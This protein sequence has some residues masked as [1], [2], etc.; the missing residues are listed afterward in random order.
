MNLLKAKSVIIFVWNVISDI[1]KILYTKKY[2]LFQQCYELLPYAHDASTAFEIAKIERNKLKTPEW[3]LIHR[4]THLATH[5][6]TLLGVFSLLMVVDMS[7]VGS[8][9]V[10]VQEFLSTD[11]TLE[12]GDVMK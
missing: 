6:T 8:Y 2:I 5:L 10:G 1:C 7:N 11:S 3:R 12:Q 9:V 4:Q